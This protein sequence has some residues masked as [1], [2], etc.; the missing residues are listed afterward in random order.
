MN[1]FARNLGLSCTNFANPHGL[2]NIEN[3]STAYDI[4]RLAIYGLK[5]ATF[6]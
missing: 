3:Y 5:D 6:R 1:F 2:G 4:S